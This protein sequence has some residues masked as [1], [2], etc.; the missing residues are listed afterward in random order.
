MAATE[1]AEK[2][3][4]AHRAKLE[5]STEAVSEQRRRLADK[6]KHAME[7]R[8]NLEARRA[9]AAEA[10]VRAAEGRHAAAEEGGGERS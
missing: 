9:L 1:G 10:E 4:K 3:I 5:A 8:D 6:D 7:V 2:R